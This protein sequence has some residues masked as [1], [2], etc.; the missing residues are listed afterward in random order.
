MPIGEYDHSEGQLVF[1]TNQG[2]PLSAS[3]RAT[4]GGFF[5]G[6]RVTLS[7]GM[8]ARY[9]DAV[10][11]EF[12]WEN[13]NV[14]L[15][16]GSFDINLGRLRVSYSLSTRLLL[17]A[18][19]QYN[20]VEDTISTNLRFSWLRDANTGLYV[21]YNEVSD[22]AGAGTGIPDRTLTIKYSRMFDLLK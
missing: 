1:M 18:L 10:T 21:V 14:D 2:A 15:P 3:A 12:S 19:V 5:G 22:L 7:A 4:F 20:D 8:M 13:N 17:Q 6:D 11:S 9:G 16:G